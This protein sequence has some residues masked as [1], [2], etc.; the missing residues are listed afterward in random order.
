MRFHPVLRR[1]TAP[2]LAWYGLAD[3]MA[4][5]WPLGG[6]VQGRPASPAPPVRD[7]RSVAIP[8]RPTGS[9]DYSRTATPDYSGAHCLDYS[10]WCNIRWI[11]PRV[12]R[13]GLLAGVC[14]LLP[15]Q[16]PI[17]LA[18]TFLPWLRREDAPCGD[19]CFDCTACGR[20]STAWPFGPPSPPS[21][22][23]WEGV[24]LDSLLLRSHLLQ[25]AVGM[26]RWGLSHS[27]NVRSLVLPRIHERNME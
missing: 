26:S 10:K 4:L 20:R 19:L 1:V 22:T 25:G 6:L 12:C 13:R 23:V 7:G 16:R 14:A 18:A 27:R 17:G 15:L 21:L 3:S 2:T 24:H 5:Q 11:T 9:R 8:T